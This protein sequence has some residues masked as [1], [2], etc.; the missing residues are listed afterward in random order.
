MFCST[1]C[2]NHHIHGI[3]HPDPETEIFT[4]VHGNNFRVTFFLE[5]LLLT[6]PALRAFQSTETPAN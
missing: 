1:L 3:H 5:D 2:I 6:D 4:H